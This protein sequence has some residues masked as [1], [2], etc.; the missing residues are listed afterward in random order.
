MFIAPIGLGNFGSRW[1]MDP[2]FTLTGLMAKCAWIPFQIN[3]SRPK[4]SEHPPEV[5]SKLDCHLGEFPT[6]S[7]MFRRFGTC[8]CQCWR[9][10]SPMW[11]RFEQDFYPRQHVNQGLNPIISNL[12]TQVNTHE[13]WTLQQ[14]R[15]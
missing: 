1:R 10:G 15:G 11:A 7:A 5:G 6:L 2:Y 4:S 9:C 14:R 8:P 12:Y 13:T 3:R